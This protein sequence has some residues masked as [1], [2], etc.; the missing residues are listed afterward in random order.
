MSEAVKRILIA[1]DE[2]RIAAFV[3]RGLQANGFATTIAENGD[4]A[5]D[6]ADSGSYDLVILDI[7]LPGQ[8]GIAV[9]ERLRSRGRLVPVVMLTGHDDVRS[10]VAGFESGADDYV[11]K[12]FRFEELLARIRAR[13]RPR[14]D[15]SD[16]LIRV[17]T[18]ALDLSGQRVIVGDR[19]VE[20]TAREF[21]LAEVFFRHPGQVLNRRQLIEMAWGEGHDPASNVVEVLVGHLRQKIGEGHITTVRS[22]GYR[23][24]RESE[25]GPD[26]APSA[27]RPAT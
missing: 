8:D 11:G 6:L 19:M 7:G 14:P 12:P 9:L 16:R 15:A 10:T 25:P 13:L 17:G 20:L 4:V 27:G 18:L 21:R 24:E 26:R 5:F 1:E 2:P 3:E 23:L 22:L